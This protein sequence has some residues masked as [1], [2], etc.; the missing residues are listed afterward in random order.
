MMTL[1][2]YELSG[3]NARDRLTGNMLV[4]TGYYMQGEIYRFQASYRNMDV[5]YPHHQLI[6]VHTRPSNT[7]KQSIVHKMQ[8][9][10]IRVD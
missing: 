3:V 6:I 8:L 2:H 5:Y 10:I 7:F 4:L 1:Y 9:S